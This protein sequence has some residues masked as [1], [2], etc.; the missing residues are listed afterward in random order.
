MSDQE[1]IIELD[2]QP[3]ELYKLLKIADLV[4]GGGEAKVVISEGY[5]F[6]NGEVEYQKRKKIYHQDIIEFNGTLLHIQ[7]NENLAIEQEINE[8]AEPAPLKQAMTEAKPENKRN[9]HSNATK[10]DSAN[11]ARKRRPISF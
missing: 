10:D 9:K 5:V 4:S 3:I 1:L 8:E 11:T 6:L 2:Q 7:V